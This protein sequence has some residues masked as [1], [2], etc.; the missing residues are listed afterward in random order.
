MHSMR[1][2]QKVLSLTNLN[3]RQM[4][5][6]H[7]FFNIITAFVNAQS[8]VTS[9]YFCHQQCSCKIVLTEPM[10]MLTV[11]AISCILTQ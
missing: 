10:L 11:L 8:T 7:L 3:K 9:K 6:H 4:D 5:E 1:G 2:G